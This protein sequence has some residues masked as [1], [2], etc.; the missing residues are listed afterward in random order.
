M[1]P[2]IEMTKDEMTVIQVVRSGEIFKATI[3]GDEDVNAVW[4][5]RT[6]AE[7]V[8]KLVITLGFSLRLRIVQN[9]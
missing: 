9:G 1:C 4:A 5:G 2:K 3:R 6:A 7:A 8:G